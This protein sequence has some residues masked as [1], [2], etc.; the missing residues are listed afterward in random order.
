MPKKNK[1]R[2]F[3]NGRP[4]VTPGESSSIRAKVG[5]NGSVV[6]L[7]HISSKRQ[8]V[9]APGDIIYYYDRKSQS[10]SDSPITD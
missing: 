7:Y 10:V 4:G 6:I 5:A 9:I 8:C 1:I 3:Y 2:V